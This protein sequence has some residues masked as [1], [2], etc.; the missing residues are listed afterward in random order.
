MRRQIYNDRRQIIIT[1]LGS[2]GIAQSYQRRRY[3]LDGWIDEERAHIVR[4]ASCLK[5]LKV[6]RK[7]SR[8]GK[9][10]FYARLFEVQ[11]WGPLVPL[12]LASPAPVRDFIFAF[13]VVCIVCQKIAFIFFV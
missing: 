10:V 12:P 9:T 5:Y 4:V 13:S 3:V 11:N 8:V 7:T 6:V 2:V 1:G